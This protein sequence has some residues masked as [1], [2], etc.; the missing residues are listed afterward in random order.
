MPKITL[1][2]GHTWA[3]VDANPTARKTMICFH[4]FPD[5][6]FGYRHQIGPW[7]RAGYRVIVPDMLGYGG[8][9]APVDPAQYTT[10]RLADDLAALL[11]AL[12]VE[13]AIVIGHDWGSYTAGRF[14]LWHRE[15][16]E[17][18]ILMSVPFTPHPPAPVTLPDVVARAPNLA[19]QLYLASPVAAPTIEAN[20]SKFLS[21]IFSSSETMASWT[22]ASDSLPKFLAEKA[23]PDQLQ[24]CI[25][26][27]D[28]FRAYEAGF[29][30]RGMTGPT[31]YYRTTHLRYQEEEAGHMASEF[32]ADLDVLSL[33]GTLDATLAPAALKL[34]RRFITRLTEIPLPDTGHW[35]L[36]QDATV[37]SEPPA[38]LDDGE[39]SDPLKG[40]R[41]KMS[42]GAWENGRGDGGKVGR[43]VLDW[44]SGTA[45]KGRL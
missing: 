33:Y 35:V 44:L 45:L 39:P 15:R 2:S 32:P 7:A 10:K 1:P 12:S 17:A 40:W 43:A 14:A 29:S 13:R 8:S 23:V 41:E 18:L 24:A 34:Q 9:D 4:G 20:M 22:A 38:Y 11:T 16:V 30:A 25:L 26:K 6:G 28:A 3:Y 27:G 31:N 19:Y 37:D 36:F 21:L 5:L 42:S